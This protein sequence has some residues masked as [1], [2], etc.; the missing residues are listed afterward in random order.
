MLGQLFVHNVKSKT[1]PL[2]IDNINDFI[3]DFTVCLLSGS[4]KKVQI[5][6]C[7]LCD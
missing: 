1:E 4:S 5:I 6:E 3:E 2:K 7:V